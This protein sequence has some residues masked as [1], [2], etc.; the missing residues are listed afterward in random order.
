MNEKLFNEKFLNFTSEI[1]F[2]FEPILITSLVAT[3]LS[4]LW[5]KAFNLSEKM[6]FVK[7]DRRSYKGTRVRDLICTINMSA[8]F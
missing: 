1:N 2:I 3:G 5:L 6:F 4:L 7:K 8:H